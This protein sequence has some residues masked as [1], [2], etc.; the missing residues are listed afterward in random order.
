MR[1]VFVKPPLL[2][3]VGNIRLE[4]FVDAGNVFDGA[5]DWEIQEIRYSLGGAL[6]WFS[7]FG[8]ISFSYAFPFNTDN[9]DDLE[10]FQFTIGSTF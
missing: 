3:D 10:K 8:P 6:H 2:E 5:S 1:P 7:P 9:D 4:G